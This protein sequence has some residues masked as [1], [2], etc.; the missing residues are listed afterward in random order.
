MAYEN[1]KK[2]ETMRLAQFRSKA[3]D[4]LHR[5]L[6]VECSRLQRHPEQLRTGWALKS[7]IDLFIANLRQ[8]ADEWLMLRRKI[9][10][11]DARWATK[12]ELKALPAGIQGLAVQRQES[13]DSLRRSNFERIMA[14]ELLRSYPGSVIRASG[15]I[16]TDLM[17]TCKALNLEFSPCPFGRL[18]R[19]AREAAGHSQTDAALAVERNTRKTIQRWEH[20]QEL[21]Q[22]ETRKDAMDYIEAHHPDGEEA[23]KRLLWTTLRSP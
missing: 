15:G 14:P 18:F 16:V 1:G 4:E 8:V 2:W 7:V 20:L 23:L 21:P 9:S 10:E 5:G 12:E 17:M 6:A 13:F 3:E 11:L 22:G 19:E